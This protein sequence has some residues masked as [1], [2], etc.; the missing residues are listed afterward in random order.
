[1]SLGR[2]LN[3][4]LAGFKTSQ[5]LNTEFI[6]KSDRKNIFDQRQKLFGFYSVNL[7]PKDTSQ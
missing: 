7:R 6:V 4:N 3:D 1:M 5:V 2:K